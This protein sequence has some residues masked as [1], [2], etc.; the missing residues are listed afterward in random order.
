MHRPTGRYLQAVESRQVIWT[1]QPDQAYAWLTPDRVVAIVHT[2]PE[3]FGE[4]SELELVPMVYTASSA[5]PLT[6]SCHG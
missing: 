1:L 5:A 6:W 4:L 3:L 2:D